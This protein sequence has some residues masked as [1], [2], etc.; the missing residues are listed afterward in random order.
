MK[1]KRIVGAVLAALLAGALIALGTRG[2]AQRGQRGT[3]QLDKVAENVYMLTGRGGNLGLSVGDSGAFLIDD[4][5]APMT[6]PI[7]AAVQSVTDKPIEFVVNTHHHGDH[8]GGNENMAKAGAHIVSHANVRKRLAQSG[9]AGLPV[10]T[11]EDAA[12]FHWN[13][14]EVRVFHA[15]NAH[16]D[17]DM[18]VH[19]KKA[20]VLHMGDTF[21]SGRY[22]YID[23]N[24][25]GSID[26]LI[27]AVDAAFKIVN[28]ET[29][30]IPGHGPLSTLSDLKEYREM[31]AVSRQRVLKL[32]E[33]G[34]TREKAVAAK[35]N[36][37]MDEQWGGGFISAERW[38]GSLYDSLTR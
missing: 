38:V 26:G 33:D 19:F 23:I 4:Q 7:L 8:T 22:P 28:E 17:G 30:L 14:D 29:K 3:V 36:A 12:V 10:L 16:T 18:M 5:F 37:D 27:A 32:I 31:L 25:G 21:F 35:P 11:F 9:G 2:K 34:K 1:R 6:E 13:G 15:P 24:S 20:N